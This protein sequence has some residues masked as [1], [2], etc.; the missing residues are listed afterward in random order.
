MLLDKLPVAQVWRA[1]DL[2]L[3]AAYPGPPPSPVRAKLDTLRSLKD[4]DFYASAVF[5]RDSTTTPSKLSLRLGNRFYPHM[6]LTIERSPDKHGF[7]FRADTHDRHICPA[8]GTREYT[9]FCQLMENNQKLAQDIETLW[10]G[11]HLATFKTY[12]RDDLARRAGN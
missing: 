7:L 8:A 6:K 9:A 1:I 5:E 10:A 11:E 4:E 3:G 12:L 2:Y